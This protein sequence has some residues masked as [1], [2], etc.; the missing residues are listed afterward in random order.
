MTTKCDYNIEGGED[1]DESL[2]VSSRCPICK[3]SNPHLYTIVQEC[4]I[5]EMG[6]DL[7]N[8]EIIDDVKTC[9]KMIK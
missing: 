6:G 4:D 8:Y 2:L 9:V 7:E 1:E 5:D 3:L